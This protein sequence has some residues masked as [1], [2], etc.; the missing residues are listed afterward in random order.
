MA[1][2]AEVLSGWNQTLRRPEPLCHRQPIG[3]QCT[4]RLWQQQCCFP[5][6]L[7]TER[8]RVQQIATSKGK[9]RCD[10]EEE[11]ESEIIG[12]EYIMRE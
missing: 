9:E 12:D 5:S 10:L 11:E 2:F 6:E 4:L 3:R 1:Q 7:I 8:Q